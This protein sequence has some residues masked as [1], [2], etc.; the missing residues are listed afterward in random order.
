MW[1]PY[2][3][4]DIKCNQ[5]L[6]ECA[7]LIEEYHARQYPVMFQSTLKEEINCL[8]QKKEAGWL[9]QIK[10]LLSKEEHF[11]IRERDEEIRL[12]HWLCQCSERERKAGRLS[13]LYWCESLEQLKIIMQITVF[14]LNRIS[15]GLE[16]ECYIDFFDFRKE[17]NLSPEYLVMVIEKGKWYDKAFLIQR[18]AKV[19]K[20]NGE[21]TY[22][23]QILFH[24]LQ[25]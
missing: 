20:E 6:R 3:N 15:L 19:F 24:Y 18:L 14:Y 25:Q 21:E 8:L 11:F 22:G 12:T 13:L 4:K 5:E 17:W 16:K 2:V 1:P 9:F 7:D 10:N 23:E